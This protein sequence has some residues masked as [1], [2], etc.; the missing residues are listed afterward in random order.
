MQKV[1]ERYMFFARV[2]HVRFYCEENLSWTL[3]GESGGN[4]KEVEISNLRQAIQI[5]RPQDKAERQKVKEEYEA[6]D[7]DIP[8]EDSVRE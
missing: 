2:S 6:L 5:I 1:D 4:F 8:Q 7:G 3:D